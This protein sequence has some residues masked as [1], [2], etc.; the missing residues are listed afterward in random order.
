MI[1]EFLQSQDSGK[2]RAIV[3]T[4]VAI[5]ALHVVPDATLTSTIKRC[6]IAPIKALIAIFCFIIVSEKLYD[7]SLEKMWM[8]I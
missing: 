8:F 2:A 3:V 1:S 7:G 6:V 4:V 5:M